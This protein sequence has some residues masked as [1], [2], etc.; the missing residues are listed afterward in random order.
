GPFDPVVL[1]RAFRLL[2]HRHEALRTSFLKSEISLQQVVS[3]AVTF[4][5]PKTTSS[6]PKDFE[7][8][9][10]REA[11]G[12]FDLTQA[13][14]LRALLIEREKEDHVSCLTLHSA[15]ADGWSIS[16]L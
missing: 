14:L 2:L 10:L 8:Q 13:P 6:N 3:D 9:C 7:E 5:L 4:S 11:R 12:P 16:V 15:I 1:E